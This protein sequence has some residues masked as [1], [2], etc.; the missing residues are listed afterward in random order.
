M[1]NITRIIA[2]IGP[3]SCK[4]NIIKKFL[5]S[6]ISLVR[7]NGSHNTLEWHNKT[8]KEIRKINKWIPILFDI[9][10]EK[11]RIDN[12]KDDITFNK[13]DRIFFSKN[14]IKKEKNVILNNEKFYNNIK[15]NMKFSADDGN[16]LFKVI[17]KR[18][19]YVE[20]LSLSDGSLSS[21]KGINIPNLFSGKENIKIS[22]KQKKYLNFAKKMKIEYVGFSFV[23]SDTQINKIKKFLNNNDIK[24]VSKIENSNGLKNLNKITNVSDAIMIDRGD[25]VAETSIYK[26]PYN[27]K[28][29]IKEVNSKNKPIIVATEMMHSMIENDKPTKSEVLDVANA[30]FDGATSTMLSGETA[31]GKYPLKSISEMIKIHKTINNQKSIYLKKNK[32]LS[33]QQLTANALESLCNSKNIH[34]LIIITKSG[35]AA[36]EIA[37]KNINQKILVITDNIHT[38][39]YLNL[40]PRIKTIKYPKKFSRRDLQ[41]VEKIMKYLF[42]IKEIDK[43]E[44]VVIVSAAYPKKGVKF[45]S[46]QTHN[47]GDVVKD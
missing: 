40:Y 32:S 2:T 35:Y 44:N 10:G 4:K 13:K 22:I 8:I 36:T 17:K 15:I 39:R 41:Y 25:L 16:L 23:E 46:I 34:K 33:I 43:Q 11:I 45:N 26:L 21:K 37:F 29:I 9:P 3:S 5:Y 31:Q 14:S 1:N 20:V 38:N 30:I 47:V 19:D 24:I 6:G 42:K 18:N 7:L 12:Q 28:K 27:Q